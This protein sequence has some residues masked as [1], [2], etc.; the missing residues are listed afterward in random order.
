MIHACYLN[1]AEVE[2]VWIQRQSGPSSLAKIDPSLSCFDLIIGFVD[3]GRYS[4]SPCGILL[5]NLEAAR[6]I[7]FASLPALRRF[8]FRFRFNKRPIAKDNQHIKVS[9]VPPAELASML[10]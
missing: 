4:P 6:T 8:R 5:A 7:S 2:I 9:K 10:I 1:T 3:V